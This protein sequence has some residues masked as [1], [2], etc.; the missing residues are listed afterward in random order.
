MSYRARAAAARSSNMV[1][2]N[3]APAA[4]A[5]MPARVRTF[6]VAASRLSPASVIINSPSM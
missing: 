5:T 6:I 3:T 2:V 1:S 4:V